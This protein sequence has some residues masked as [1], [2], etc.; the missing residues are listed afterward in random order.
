M[1]DEEYS[2]QHDTEPIGEVALLY[3]YLSIK[4]ASIWICL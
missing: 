4:E 1:S 3:N 2:A